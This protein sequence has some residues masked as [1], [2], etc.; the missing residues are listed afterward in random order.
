MRTRRN[1]V[2][3][4]CSC[5]QAIL[6]YLT[7]LTGMRKAAE[8]HEFRRADLLLLLRALHEFVRATGDA[9][10]HADNDPT[11]DHCAIVDNVHNRRPKQYVHATTAPIK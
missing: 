11:D 8:S 2:A 10:I 4:E 3:I 9:L 7:E 5:G 6:E 1:T